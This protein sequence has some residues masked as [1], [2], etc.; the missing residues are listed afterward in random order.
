[1]RFFS[2]SLVALLVVTDTA[3]SSPLHVHYPYS[4]KDSHNVPEKWSRVGP[5]PAAHSITLNIGLKQDQFHEL[6]KHL[7]EGRQ[8]P[9]LIHIPAYTD[10]VLLVSTPCHTRYGKHLTSEEVNALIAPSS[11]ALSEV[12]KWLEDHGINSTQLS[13]SSAKEWITV[14]LPVNTT[15]IL[16]DTKYS[17]YQHQDGTQLIRAPTWSL[18]THLHKH[19]DTIQPTNSFFRAGASS[20]TLKKVVRPLAKKIAKRSARK[21]NNVPKVSQKLKVA[22]A[23]NFS[24]VTI[25]C[26]RTLY[27]TIDYV[28]KVP[29]KNQ[30]G[31]TNYLGEVSNRSDVSIFLQ[32]FRP[33]AVSAAQAFTIDVIDRADNQQTPE[34][35]T[36]LAVGKDLE[37]NLDAETILGLGYPTPLTTYNTGGLPPFIPDAHTP[38]NF[39]EV[40]HPH[41]HLYPISHL[42]HTH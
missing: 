14:T 16:L 28:P 6:E 15:E 19:I 39:N 26:L 5:A 9:Y 7:Y 30:V 40:P 11:H 8:Y 21:L 25:T 27:G 29:G 34:N 4:V 1:M 38:T 10:S 2:S 42:I 13:Y 31:L 18:P 33:D 35:S 17:V 41:P 20:G 24:A 3:L 23:C 22:Q 32:R 12:H 36:E 37:G